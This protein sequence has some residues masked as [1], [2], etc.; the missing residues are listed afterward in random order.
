MAS[1]ELS[2]RQRVLVLADDCN[3]EW[4]SLPALIFR[5]VQVLS[6]YVDIVLVT[7]IRNQNN[8]EKAGLVNVEVVYLDTEKVAAPIYKLAS[9]LSGD[10]NKA[11]TVKVALSYPSYLVFEWVAWR[12]FKTDIQAGKFDLIHRMSPMSPTIPSP[13][14][15]WCQSVPFV[16]GPL[17]GGLAW[18][19]QFKQEMLREREWM[20][21]I[22]QLH[23]VL[24]FYQSTY[25]KAA[26]ILAAYPHTIADLPASAAE[27]IIDFSEGGVDPAEFPMPDKVIH[28]KITVLFVGRLVPFKLPEVLV[29]SFAA[30]PLLQQH[31]LVIVG[32]GP[33]RPRLEQMSAAAGLTHCIEFKGTLP[34]AEVGQLMRDSEIFAFPSIREQGGGVL[35][36]AAMSGMA[37]VVVDYGGPAYRVPNGC[38]IRVPLGT[39][40]QLTE[41]FTAAL[42]DLVTH[43]K[44]ILAM[45]AAAREFTCAHYAW[46]IK[47]QNTLAVYAWVLG[48]RSTKPDFRPKTAV[49]SALA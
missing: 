2:Q 39:L 10:P 1:H 14:V 23:R 40:S 48:K 47:A 36:L 12:R 34:Q 9:F 6:Q 17:L 49:P 33:E 3:P 32:D 42:E 41:R 43:P 24:P 20:N 4:H 27:R 45:G 38:G 25:Q 18:P 30:S 19:E 11:M 5:Y 28:D 26:A 13:I 31:R 29:R 44:Q 7:Q 22:R 16:I 46:E 35:T 15:S 21:Y 8:I 37:L